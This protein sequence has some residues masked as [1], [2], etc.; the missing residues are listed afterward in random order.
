MD[1]TCFKAN[2][3]CFVLASVYVGSLYVW[4]SNEDRYISHEIISVIKY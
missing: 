4:K 2:F 1:G 3:S